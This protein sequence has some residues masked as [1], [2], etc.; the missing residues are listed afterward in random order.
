MNG[1]ADNNERIFG[2]ETC[3]RRVSSFGFPYVNQDQ[4]G[5]TAH[6]AQ[7]LLHLSD[8]ADRFR[9]PTRALKV[10]DDRYLFLLD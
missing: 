8:A 4:L 3:D 10:A 9:R 5:R 7:Q 1:T 2:N 6:C